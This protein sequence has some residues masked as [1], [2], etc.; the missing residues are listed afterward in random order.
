MLGAAMSVHPLASVDPAATLGDG[1]RVG[2]FAV[3]EPG[4]V[5]GE[6]CEI[7]S[8]AVIKAH[9]RLG[10]GVTVH[11]GAVIGGDP[12]DL[13]FQP[14]DSTV[15]VGDGTTL[16][17]GVTLHRGSKPGGATRIGRGCFL[18]AYVHVAH[19][20]VLGDGVIIAN[21]TMLAGHVHVADRAFLAG[22]VGVHQ[23]CRVGRQAMLG[24]NAK[25]VQDALPFSILDGV[26]AR[27]RGVNVIGLRRA[28][29]T[30]AELREVRESYRLLLRAGLGLAAALREIEAMGG[31]YAT[32]IAAF[33][34]GCRRGFAHRRASGGA[35]E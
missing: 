15:E 3:I 17:E 2:P 32:E 8:H 25:L 35:G 12:Q 33:V 28:G 14:C 30:A 9:A 23:F 6:G 5:V 11:E 10:R 13:S 26:P 4:A 18:M 24:G 20:N 22:G 1:T 29:L 21:N 19:D 31:P 7:R 16:R 34:R 27:W